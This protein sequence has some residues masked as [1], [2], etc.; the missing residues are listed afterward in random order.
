MITRG[1]CD[2]IEFVPESIEEFI[3]IESQLHFY[4]N[5]QKSVGASIECWIRDWM[6][7]HI[8]NVDSDLKEFLSELRLWET[9]RTIV[10]FF[11]SPDGRWDDMTFW[12]ELSASSLTPKTLNLMQ[13]ALWIREERC[14]EY[15]REEA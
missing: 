3:D 14:K 6:E 1:Y 10:E 11:N 9:F 8:E 7:W 2:S 12:A 4:R 13:R 15:L 5:N